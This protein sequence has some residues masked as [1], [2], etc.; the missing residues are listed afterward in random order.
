MI[1]SSSQFTLET[2]KMTKTEFL[3]GTLARLQDEV[4]T[5]LDLIEDY[6]SKNPRKIGFWASIR[7]LMPP[8]EAIGEV[9]GET[10]WDFLRNHLDVGPSSLAWQMF[11]H[12]LMHGDLMRHVE[13]NGQRVDWEISMFG[14]GNVIGSSHIGLDVVHIY[15]KLVDYLNAEIAKN[16]QT[17]VNVPMGVIYQ[18][19]EQYIID[20]F[21]KLK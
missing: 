3:E 20:D 9:I 19:P 7:L 21:N 13:Y 12:S 4:G 6:N 18:N 8:I 5:I 16:D 11:R 15:N 2:Q 14:V 1:S 17:I 10:P